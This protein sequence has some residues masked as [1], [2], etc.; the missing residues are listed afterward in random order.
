VN[1]HRN[2]LLF[3]EK[4][5]DG[6]LDRREATSL[7]P[8]C[9]AAVK[10]AIAAIED[11][12]TDLNDCMK[13]ALPLS[14][15]FFFV[16]S[17]QPNTGTASGLPLEAKRAELPAKLPANRSESVGFSSNRVRPNFACFPCRQHV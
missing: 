11:S 7:P 17:S 2:G 6:R 15:H 9:G 12:E 16:H 4:V 5:F 14:I 13:A 10:T 3:K 8:S 1:K